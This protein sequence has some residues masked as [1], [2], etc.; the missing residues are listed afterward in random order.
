M[1][2]GATCC[3]ANLPPY[4]CDTAAFAPPRDPNYDTSGP[5]DIDSIM[6]YQSHAYAK[7]PGLFT[8]VSKIPGKVVPE[9]NP[10]FPS[11]LDF[12]RVCKIYSK[13]CKKV[14]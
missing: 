9:R 12:E 13:Q 1:P 8:L 14:Q 3:D 2:A 10:A 5:Y 6:H 11:K 7:G 4:C